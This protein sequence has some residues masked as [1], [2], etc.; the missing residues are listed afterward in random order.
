MK[1]SLRN[2]IIKAY[3]L[4]PDSRGRATIKYKC[5]VLL[6]SFFWTSDLWN[7]CQCEWWLRFKLGWAETASSENKV[8][9]STEIGKVLSKQSQGLLLLYNFHCYMVY[10]DF[11]HKSS[12]AWFFFLFSFF[13]FFIWQ[14]DQ[15]L[16]N[17]KCVRMKHVFYP[18]LVYDIITNRNKS[19]ASTTWYPATVLI[20]VVVHV[21]A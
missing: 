17:E 14:R 19:A 15:S 18:L 9:K 6:L 7:I 11:S 5:K 1:R 12:L 2:S 21:L 8:Q 20:F 4:P 16:F 3:S 10:S 13:F